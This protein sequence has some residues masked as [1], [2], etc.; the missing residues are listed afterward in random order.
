VRLPWRKGTLPIWIWD[1]VGEVR[2]ERVESRRWVRD[3]EERKVPSPCTSPSGLLTGTEGALMRGWGAAAGGKE[4]GATVCGGK[5]AIGA[6]SCRR[7][8]CGKS[9]PYVRHLRRGCGREKESCVHRGCGKEEE[10][11]SRGADWA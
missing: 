10:E 8:A 4:E 7:A 1:K 2:G 9:A 6:C 11:G 5:R 3:A